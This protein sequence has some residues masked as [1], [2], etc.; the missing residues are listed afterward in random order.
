MESEIME[1]NCIICETDVE[2]WDIAYPENTKTVHPIGGTAFR[3]YGHYGS[4]VFDPMDASFLEIVI[5]CSCLKDRLHYTYKGVNEQYRQEQEDR[6][7]EMD[8]LL[9]DLFDD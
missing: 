8:E 1:T 7:A 6:R 4:T 3:T 5:C 2:N 9:D